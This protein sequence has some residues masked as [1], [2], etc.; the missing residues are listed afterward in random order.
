MKKTLLFSILAVI[1]NSELYSQTEYIDYRS[2]TNP[3][4]WKNRKPFLDYWQQDVH[5][6]IYAQLND[7]S[8][9]ITGHEELTYWNNSPKELSIVYFHLYNN[10][11][12]KGSYLADL[13]K[14]NN[15]HLKFNKYRNND[16]GTNIEKIVVGNTPLKTELDNTVLKVY[17][18]KPLN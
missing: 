13:Y 7:S 9:I 12:C 1:L 15:Y 14:N 2:Q 10:A 18:E 3:L 17:L 4:Y 5:Y 11:Q 8:D 16:K 6:N